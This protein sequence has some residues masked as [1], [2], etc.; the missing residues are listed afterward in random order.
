[1]HKPTKPCEII[2]FFPADLSSNDDGSVMF[3]VA[4]DSYS[5]FLF[6]LEATQANTDLNLLTAIKQLMKNKDFTRYSHPFTLVLH[7]YEY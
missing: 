6:Q 5:E 4:L 2:S 3:Y 1:M 7:K